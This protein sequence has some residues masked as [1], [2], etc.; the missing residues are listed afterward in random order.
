MNG[1]PPAA[2]KSLGQHFL[3]DRRA[4]AS[5]VN[6]ADLSADDLVVEIGP[7]RGALTR[8]LVERAG[9]LVAVEVDALLATRLREK[10]A[11]RPE[12]SVHRRRRA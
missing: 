2:K 4:I 8:P 1:R 11:D 10:Y 3:V 7:G 12:F 5:I 6:A 9:R